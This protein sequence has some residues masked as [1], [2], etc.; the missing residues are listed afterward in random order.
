MEDNNN[1]QPGF[2]LDYIELYNWG[3]FDSSIEKI[4]PGCNTSL[5]TGANGSGKTTI[6]DALLTLLVPNTKRFYNQSSGAEQK[7]ERDE[8]S[9]VLGYYGKS[10]EEE[11]AE[12]KHQMLRKR[13]DCSVL[14]GCFF[15]AS[16]GQYVSLI[17]VRWFSSTELKRAYIVSPNKFTIKE[18]FSN[19][20]TRGDWR[21]QLRKQFQ[22]TEINDSFTAYSDQFMHLF[23]MRS[24]KALSLFN[25]TVGIKVIGNLNEFIRVNMLEEGQAEQEFQQLR[26]NFQNL[27]ETHRS[28]QKAE[29]QLEMLNPIITQGE[30]FIQLNKE[31]DEIKQ[32][33]DAAKIYYPEQEKVLRI[34]VL[35]SLTD[36]LKDVDAN[37]KV[38]D[39]EL[40]NLKKQE[41]SLSN[42]IENNDANKA[43]ERLDEQ[44]ERHIKE[45]ER[46]EAQEKNYNSLIASLGW[47]QLTSEEQ[48]RLNIELIRKD[49]KNIS[50]TQKTI[51]ENRVSKSVEKKGIEKECESLSEDITSLRNRKSQIPRKNLEIRQGILDAI[52]I[53]SDE[54][55]F[56]GELIKVIQEEKKWEGAIE[57]LLHSFGLCLLVPE[58]YIR[59]VNQY[60]H[61][62]NLKGKVIFHKVNLLAKPEQIPDIEENSVREKIE[63]KSESVFENWLEYRLDQQFNYICT[64]D[65]E[66]FALERKALMPSGLSK[67]FERHEKDDSER[68]VGL[69]NYI[70]GWDNKEKLTALINDLSKK[71][72]TATLLGNEI[73]NLDKEKK[74]LEDRSVNLRELLRF[75]SY[76]EIDWTQDQES[77]VR[78]KK[79]RSDLLEKA[80]DLKKLIDQ[81]NTTKGLVEK[82]GKRRDKLIEHSG[83]IKT[84]IK[85]HQDKLDEINRLLHEVKDIDKTLFY[86]KLKSFIQVVEDKNPLTQLVK[87]RKLTEE[88]LGRTIATKKEAASKLS[89]K[90][91]TLMQKFINPPKELTD[92]FPDWNGDTINLTTNVE[93]ID[94]FIALNKRIDEEDLP[95]H[96][97]RFRSY[98][99]DAILERVT[100]FKT[101]LDLRLE[102]IDQH[103]NNLNMSLKSIDFS[104]HPP[105]YIQLLSKTTRDVTVRDFKAELQACMP[106]VADFALKEQES[107]L[108]N[109]FL[110]IKSLI[111]R[112]NNDIHLRKKVIDVR[113]WLEFSAEEY[114][115][116]NN[117]RTRYYDSSGSLSGG[118]KAQFTY[119]VLG[120][121]IAYQF[122]INHD[123]SQMKSFR[124]ITVDEAFSKLD[125]EKS[126]YLMELCKQLHLQLLVVTPLDKIHIAEPYISACH[127]VENKN[128][129]R[130]RVFNLTMDEYY[131]RKKEFDEISSTEQ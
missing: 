19:I 68:R 83:S 118:E 21:K 122:G 29:Q 99:N 4:V 20:D 128:R 110:K 3:T 64:E 33:Q 80:N 31:V 7:K 107:W 44:I 62:T 49:D 87:E 123:G 37:I 12:A 102:E 119:T 55:P 25:L 59:S 40:E 71:E 22:K 75:E 109:Q 126:N 27:L 98:M 69:Q 6:V 104:K 86:E 24:E 57:N 39:G 1:H 47:P 116:E 45:K 76:S 95:R 9:Y 48:F 42:S 120:A 84:E 130:S 89:V 79:Q 60:V 78:L 63:I 5:L 28:I 8:T 51:Y 125:P 91:S 90:L 30:T 18:H 67:N 77:S 111:D 35:N 108:E 94:E 2:R 85:T 11:G 50:S 101:S 14:L 32:L 81:L 10:V 113:N 36:E 93:N 103:M 100:S 13:S 74:V 82:E 43:L 58:K 88:N 114:Y 26:E 70:L 53:D 65:Q 121:A 72:K 54:I 106:N 46:K 105:T 97:K 23:G 117:V 15:N 127:F 61:Q 16:T 38:S 52:G 112:L 66:T 41:Y 34:E 96:K 56:V 92:K 17:Q 73:E 129:T 124:F 115:R 131:K